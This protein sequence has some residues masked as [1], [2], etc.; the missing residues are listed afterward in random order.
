[1]WYSYNAMKQGVE[2]ISD[3]RYIELYTWIN[4]TSTAISDSSKIKSHCKSNLELMSRIKAQS[5]ANKRAWEFKQSQKGTQYITLWH[6]S[7]HWGPL[8]RLPIHNNSLHSTRQNTL[9]HLY[10]QSSK[11]CSNL[12]HVEYRDGIKSKGDKIGMPCTHS[13]VI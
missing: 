8:R 10:T 2:E 13:T 11:N 9:N 7:C 4:S 1:M 12:Q 3:W 5:S 6:P